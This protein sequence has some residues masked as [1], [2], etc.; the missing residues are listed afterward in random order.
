MDCFRMILW[1]ASSESSLSSGISSTK[2]YF[3]RL[4]TISRCEESK[5]PPSF[6]NTEVKISQNSDPANSFLGSVKKY[7]SRK[8][9]QSFR[10]KSPEISFR[11]L[12]NFSHDTNWNSFMGF[13]LKD[14]KMRLL[15]SQSLVRKHLYFFLRISRIIVLPSYFRRSVARAGSS[16]VKLV[17]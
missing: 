5:T 4:I 2:L 11:I 12:M 9:A 16:P 13:R 8:S 6:R 10:L 17:R 3:I 7:P 15:M 1:N 14:R